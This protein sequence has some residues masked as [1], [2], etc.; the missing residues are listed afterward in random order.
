MRSWDLGNLLG[1]LINPSGINYARLRIWYGQVANDLP[2]SAK[3]IDLYKENGIKRIRI[4][5][6]NP[7]TPQ[8][9]R[10]SNIELLVCVSNGDIE[11]LANNAAAATDWVQR[12]IKAYFP[13]V[14]F[15]YIAIENEIKLNDAIALYVLPV[16]L[17]YT[18][19]LT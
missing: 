14:R 9:V 6:P 15:Q 1:F 11:N 16:M 17:F 13:D 19:V 4:F 18:N 5:D 8:A 3:V 2:P 10:G 12:K 7:K